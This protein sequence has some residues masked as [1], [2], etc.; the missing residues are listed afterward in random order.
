MSWLDYG[1]IYREVVHANRTGRESDIVLL[2][3]PSQTYKR[4]AGNYLSPEWKRTINAW[5]AAQEKPTGQMPLEKAIAF[6][7]VE[8]SSLTTLKAERID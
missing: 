7:G 1:V 6:F 3:I 2:H 8:D 5:V 4:F